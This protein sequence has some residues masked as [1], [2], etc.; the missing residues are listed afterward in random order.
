MCVCGG[1]RHSGLLLDNSLLRKVSASWLQ[2]CF[3]TQIVYKPPGVLKNSIFTFTT[4]L[5]EPHG[6]LPSWVSGCRRLTR[7]RRPPS[8]S[9]ILSARAQWEAHTAWAV[10]GSAS[11]PSA[12]P[13]PRCSSPGKW[14]ERTRE[15]THGSALKTTGTPQLTGAT[16]WNNVP[17]NWLLLPLDSGGNQLSLRIHS[18][19]SFPELFYMPAKKLFLRI[20]IT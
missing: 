6:K 17:A 11:A 13:L 2:F 8:G 5:E 3:L 4:G 16:R 14:V 18:D 12:G 9:L 20:K 15:V 7:W 1:E 19:L 10:A